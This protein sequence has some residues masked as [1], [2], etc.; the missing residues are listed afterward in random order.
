M[1]AFQPFHC[2]M[3]WASSFLRFLESRFSQMGSPEFNLFSADRR[4]E[5]KEKEVNEQGG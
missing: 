5:E 2:K 1:V 4:A 3:S